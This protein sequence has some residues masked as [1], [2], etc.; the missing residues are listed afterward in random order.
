MW[1]VPNKHVFLNL[2][3]IVFKYI[4]VLSIST[5]Y[6][7]QTIAAP[8]IWIFTWPYLI[9]VILGLMGDETWCSYNPLYSI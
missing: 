5:F 9:M 4:I 1:S 7:Y 3:E 6:P 8:A 2:E